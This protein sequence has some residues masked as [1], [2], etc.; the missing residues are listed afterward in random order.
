M[1][2]VV[3]I[4]NPS[5][6]AVNRTRIA[7]PKGKYIV[8]FFDQDAREFIPMSSSNATIICDVDNSRTD[9]NCWLH[10]KVKV[11]GHSISFMMIQ[12]ND[13]NGHIDVNPRMEN[14]P[15]GA[16]EITNNLQALEYV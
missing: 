2:F 3:A 15:N 8:K 6:H 13:D 9:E 16:L 12:R 10:A 11:R 4:F 14:A 5:L 1:N 7:V